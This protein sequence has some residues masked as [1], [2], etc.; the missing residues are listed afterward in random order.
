M[1]TFIESIKKTIREIVAY[2]AKVIDAITQGAVR[3]NHITLLSLV[4]YVVVALAI[5][6]NRLPEAALMLTFFGLFDTLD[7]ELA[8]LQKTSSVFGMMFDST[9]DRVKEGIVYI[10]IAAL[11]IEED[12]SLGVLFAITALT[13]SFT[14]SYIS[15]RGEVALLSASKSPKDVEG[16]NNSFRTGYF[17]FEMRT[18]VLI[19][20]LVSGYIYASVIINALGAFITLVQ[21]F[22]TITKTLEATSSD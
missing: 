19:V 6:S 3:P 1:K 10:G 4:G 16:I 2:D 5:S 9:A 17:G 21:R 22:I 11:F 18:F 13:I 15:A 14:V 20:G 7:G 12:L 8:R